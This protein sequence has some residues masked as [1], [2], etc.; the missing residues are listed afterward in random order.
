MVSS[1]YIYIYIHE[2][3]SGSTLTLSLVKMH[4]KLWTQNKKN[5]GQVQAHVISSHLQ[6]HYPEWRSNC[7]KTLWFQNSSSWTWLRDERIGEATWGE[8]GGF[9]LLVEVRRC[10]Y[11]YVSVEIA[12]QLTV[13]KS[14]ASITVEMMGCRGRM[15]VKTRLRLESSGQDTEQLLHF[16]QLPRLIVD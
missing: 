6:A 7:P 10:H 2:S 12:H 8:A 1:T 11:Y 14:R 9:G 5:A 16:H 13:M 15:P 3:V 4:I